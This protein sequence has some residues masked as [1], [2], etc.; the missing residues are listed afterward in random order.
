MSCYK[1]SVMGE[2]NILQPGNIPSEIANGSHF[3]VGAGQRLIVE[4]T[5]H[6]SGREYVVAVVEPTVVNGES[7]ERIVRT[8]RVII[9]DTGKT[10][11]YAFVLRDDNGNR[12][13]LVPT[14]EEK[15]GI[16]GNKE[17]VK[18]SLTGQH[19]SAKLNTKDAQKMLG[20]ALERGFIKAQ[21]A[22]RNSQN[23]TTYTI[24]DIIHSKQ[25]YV[26]QVKIREAMSKVVGSRESQWEIYRNSTQVPENIRTDISR[27]IPMEY[28]KGREKINTIAALGHDFG[29]NPIGMQSHLTKTKENG[30]TVFKFS[31]ETKGRIPFRVTGTTEERD[32]AFQTI[33]ENHPC[34]SFQQLLSLRNDLKTKLNATDSEIN[35]AAFIALAHSKS[36]SGIL[37]LNDRESLELG[38]RNA[39]AMVNDWN[40]NKD[41]VRNYGKI[42]FNRQDIVDNLSYVT[43]DAYALRPADA[44]RPGLMDDCCQGGYQTVCDRDSLENVENISGNTFEEC[45]FAEVKNANIKLIDENG[46]D[47]VLDAEKNPF[48]LYAHFGESNVRYGEPFAKEDGLHIPVEV[49][50]NKGTYVT[51][52]AILETVAEFNTA[53][54]VKVFLDVY[55]KTEDN[56]PSSKCWKGFQRKSVGEAKI[57]VF[58]Q[59]K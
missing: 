48:A 53:H 32:K 28:G 43:Y 33:R 57:N 56:L 35:Q 41:L 42:E 40:N 5:R 17:S 44:A 11:A 51:Q 31:E 38:L 18:N 47:I 45:M 1:N 25:V 3:A 6:E 34:S 7:R 39:E 58:F 36:S 50:D 13:S 29:M 30:K 49:Q 55:V 46:N 4:K 54:S 9:G 14:R 59:D 37:N 2:G 19:V 22:A 52:K 20:I 16:K 26:Y 15:Y 23:G 12:I 10:R 8:E 27:F 24:H 21:N